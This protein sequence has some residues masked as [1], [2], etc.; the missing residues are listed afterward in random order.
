M[1]IS[2][3]GVTK[4]YSTICALDNISLTLESNKIYGL[5]GRNGAGKTTL[6]NLTT[7]RIFPTAGDIYVDGKNIKRHED[8]VDNIYYT[9]ES[10]L[11]PEGFTIKNVFKWTGEFF[12]NFDM[13]YAYELCNKF[14][15]DINKRVKSLSTGY[16]SISKIITAIST[17]ADILLFD[18]PVLGLDAYHRDLFYKEL[19]AN[20]LKKPKTIVLSTHIIDEIVEILN[21][22][23]ILKNKK[24]AIQDS[25]ENLLNSAYCVSGGAKEVKEYILNKKCIHIE[26]LSSYAMSTVIEKISEQDKKSASELGLDITKVE[27]QKLFIYLTNDGGMYHEDNQVV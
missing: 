17:N 11:Y 18:E 26:Y 4:N 22:V 12:K 20:Y 19:L 6:L 1:N 13:K 24:I 14:G 7:N 9:G 5:F 3:S 21:D 27:L 2:F 15:L 23:I 10:D 25:V 16:N 8:V